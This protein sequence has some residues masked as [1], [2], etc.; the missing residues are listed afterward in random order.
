MNLNSLYFD[1]VNYALSLCVF[2]TLMV[3]FYLVFIMGLK[4]LQ[5]I[6]VPSESSTL[7]FFWTFIPSILVLMLC[8]YNVSYVLKDFEMVVH[9]TVKIIGR[10]WYWSYEYEDY[11]YDSYMNQLI[12]NVDKPLKLNVNNSYRLLVTSSDVIHSFSVP[13]LA[14]KCDAIPGRINQVIV[15]PDYLGVFT[16]YCSELCGAGHSYMP[17]VVEVVK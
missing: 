3:F 12:N 10:Q 8:I 6:E 7:E 1:V 13:D 5:T 2:I 17:I 4:G 15:I 11:N 16:G 14:I 9:K